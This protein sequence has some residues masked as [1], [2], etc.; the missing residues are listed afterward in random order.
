MRHWQ[1]LATR[2]MPTK[3]RKGDASA[4]L[5]PG[6]IDMSQDEYDWIQAISNMN[7]ETVKMVL[8]GAF[9]GHLAKN[10]KHY[11]RKISYLARTRNISFQE[12][13]RRL[14]R[15]EELG[16]IV[17]EAPIDLEAETS[18]NTF[19]PDAKQSAKPTEEGGK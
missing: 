13:F 16:E 19:F 8:L 7:A 6:Y 15:G 5:T 18:A 14:A 17:N 9:R 3:D 10:K 12:C 1:T 11:I 4:R 2:T